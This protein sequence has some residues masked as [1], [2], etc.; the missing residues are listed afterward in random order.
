MTVDDL[1]NIRH[2]AAHLLAAAVKQVWPGAKNAIGPAIDTGFYQDFDMGDV[3]VSEDD[4]GK[5]EDKMREILKSWGP[6]VVQEVTVDQARQDFADNPY[7]LELI[8]DFGQE[9]KTIT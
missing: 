6:F 7:K 8:N 4:L 3:K 9:G 5:I 2:S 1:Q